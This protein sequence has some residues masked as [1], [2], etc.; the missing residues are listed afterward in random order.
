VHIIDKQI[1][2]AMRQ[3]DQDFKDLSQIVGKPKVK[4]DVMPF[5][6]PLL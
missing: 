1:T 3:E 6:S 5:K 4:D 2:E